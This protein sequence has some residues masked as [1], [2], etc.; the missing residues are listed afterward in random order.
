MKKSKAETRIINFQRITNLKC[1][2]KNRVKRDIREL[3]ATRHE[4]N[5]QPKMK[6]EANAAQV[7]V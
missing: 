1:H 2:G 5:N 4:L 6:G 7:V 3:N